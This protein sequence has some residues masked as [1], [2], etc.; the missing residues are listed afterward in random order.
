MLNFI[1]KKCIR[2]NPDPYGPDLKLKSISGGHSFLELSICRPWKKG[3]YPYPKVKIPG[4]KEK[5]LG[6]PDLK[7]VILSAPGDQAVVIESK[8]LTEDK[9][10]TVDNQFMKNEACYAI[11]LSECRVISLSTIE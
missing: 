4:R 8:Q 2:V 5:Y 3:P 7:F 10:I 11:P 9:K 6:Y 1:R